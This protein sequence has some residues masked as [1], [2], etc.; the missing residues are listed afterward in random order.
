[1]N[2]PETTLVTLPLDD[3]INSILGTELDG[4]ECVYVTPLVAQILNGVME[5]VGYRRALIKFEDFDGELLDRPLL[6][7]RRSYDLERDLAYA[8]RSYKHK[9]RIASMIRSRNLDLI[10]AAIKKQTGMTDKQAGLL[11][12]KLFKDSA[13]AALVAKEAFGVEKLIEKEEEL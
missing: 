12:D 7:N 10:V 6:W 4:L 3:L 13:T 5:S 2:K 1:M 11:A 8:R 9:T